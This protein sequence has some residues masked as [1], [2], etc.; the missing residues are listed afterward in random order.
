MSTLRRSATRWASGPSSDGPDAH[1][2]PDEGRRSGAVDLVYRSQLTRGAGPIKECQLLGPVPS[3]RAPTTPPEVC[4]SASASQH[5]RHASRVTLLK[6][7]TWSTLV[8]D[9]ANVS[10]GQHPPIRACAKQMGAVVPQ[11]LG[12]EFVQTADDAPTLIGQ[13]HC[14]A[15]SCS[16]HQSASVDNW[17]NRSCR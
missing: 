12:G 9:E 11:L 7:P 15:R 13:D 14:T 4:G 16:R 5:P 17:C 8:V 10:P 6:V 2:R 3:G 1:R